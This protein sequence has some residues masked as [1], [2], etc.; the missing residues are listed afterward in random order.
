[1]K[2]TTGLT[3]HSPRLRRAAV[4]VMLCCSVA[5]SPGPVW[6]APEDQA[7]LNFVGADIESVIKAVGHYTGMTFIIDPRVKGTLTLVSERSISKAQAFNLLTSQLRLQGYAVVTGDGFAK[8]VPEAEAK[9]Q[10]SPTQVGVGGGG[11]RG[12]QVATQI[13]HLNYESAANLTAVLRPL[14]SP[15][16]SIMAN[17]GNNSLVITD[18]A[19]N[20]RRLTKIISALD[21]PIAADVDIVPVRHGVASDMATLIEKLLQPAPGGDSGRVSVVADPRTN[22]LV[23]RAPSRARANLAKS[24]IAKLDQPTSQ[25]G[26]VHVV[27]LKNADATKLAATLRAVVSSD[28][29]ALQ[30]NQ[31]GTSGGSVQTT[32][33]AQGA[34]GNLGPGQ[35]TM[36]QQG[37]QQQTGG[38]GGSGAG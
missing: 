10:A 1:M 18:Y 33:G 12:D 4:A 34:S 35:S 7:A 3:I 20:L 11:V 37:N 30:Q 19:D 15:N 28:S 29:S 8:V 23:I 17:P 21:A 38:G 13:Y 16:N 9:L 2:K 36:N 32:G 31:Q 14:I 27:Y 5:G 26:N 22:S 6:A 24:L 25:A